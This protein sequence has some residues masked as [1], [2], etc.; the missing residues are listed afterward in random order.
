M[1]VCIVSAL[2]AAGTGC[3]PT[4][5]PVNM[6]ARKSAISETRWSWYSDDSALLV[7]GSP[8]YVQRILAGNCFE[9]LY[10]QAGLQILQRDSCGT[11][12]AV[13]Q[14]G[15]WSWPLG[16]SLQIAY[17]GA[18]PDKKEFRLAGDTL[19]L[20][21]PFMIPADSIAGQPVRSLR[22]YIKI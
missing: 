7:N 13:Q 5:I 21:D 15:L 16:D 14:V 20:F 22:T 9:T 8:I 3:I 4:F 18:M 6:D 17:S 2:V 1:C 10:F 19:Q 12:A 11:A